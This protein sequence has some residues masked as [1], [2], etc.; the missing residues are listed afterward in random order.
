MVSE[1]AK[2]ASVCGLPDAELSRLLAAIVGESCRI[3]SRSVLQ[4]RRFGHCGRVVEIV[5]L[6]TGRKLIVK[7]RNDRAECRETLFYQHVLHRASGLVPVYLGGTT[8]ARREHAL[9]L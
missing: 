1:E 3:A 7:L 4:Q 5:I 8:T 2:S 9:V 6:G